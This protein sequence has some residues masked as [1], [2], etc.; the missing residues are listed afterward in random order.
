MTNVIKNGQHNRQYEMSEG[1][2]AYTI[3]NIGTIGDGT[4]EK[5]TETGLCIT[6]YTGNDGAL[7]LP[8]YIDGYPVYAIGKKAFFGNR[9]LQ[10]IVLPDTIQLIGDWAFARC[11]MLREI[12]LPKRKIRLGN[13]VFLQSK[14]LEKISF[15]G[16]GRELARLLAAAAVALGAE[17]LIEP[18][19]TGND[20]WCERLDARILAFLGESE[21]S[22]LKDL[23]YCAEEDMGA[24]QE[25]CLRKQAHRK[26]EIVFLRL[27]APVGMSA[28]I[29]QSLTDYLRQRTKGCRDEAAW[30]T[31]KECSGDA[32]RYLNILY[33]IGAV[34]EEN[35]TEML[36]DLEEGHIELKA[37][38]LRIWQ[39]K[40]GG[41]AVWESLRLEG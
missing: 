31:I 32:Q 10:Q 22:V 7:S 3:N 16:C 11:Y 15:A 28:S 38:L 9:Q 21:E 30:E 6:D 27:S 8:S 39:D 29:R 13:Q 36:E 20:N 23:V 24:K 19:L 1:V 34:H 12:V 35:I 18:V 41:Q 14:L 4:E 37:F 26:A 2:L 40:Q 25:A 17:Y 5:K 33:E